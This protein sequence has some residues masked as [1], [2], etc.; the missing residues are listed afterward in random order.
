MDLDE[1]MFAFV[2]HFKVS[3]P[4]TYIKKEKKKKYS[5]DTV[6]DI[7]YINCIMYMYSYG[8]YIND[9]SNYTGLHP[10]HVN[11][12]IDAYNDCLIERF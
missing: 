10:D 3:N 12:I 7:D 11:V 9:I 2:D 6:I 5:F 8:T 4:K 1:N